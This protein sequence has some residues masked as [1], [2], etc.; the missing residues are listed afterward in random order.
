M[1]AAIAAG[2][3]RHTALLE[4]EKA[5]L[6][7]EATAK[8][9]A[10][11][12]D[13]LKADCAIAE[14]TLQ[15]MTAARQTAQDAPDRAQ[16]D[17]DAAKGYKADAERYA[18]ATAEK[19]DL[20]KKK[21]Q[22]TEAQARLGEVRAAAE[23]PVR[24]GPINLK[25]QEKRRLEETAALLDTVGCP[26]EYADS[27][28][29][30][31]EAVKARDTLPALEAEIAA[32]TLQ[33]AEAAERELAAI[34]EAEGALVAV[35]FDAA[36][37][38]TVLCTIENTKTAA[39]QYARL[40]ELKREVQ[41]AE[42]T[43]RG[44]DL[45]FHAA[46][47]QLASLRGKLATAQAAAAGYDPEALRDVR[48]ALLDGQRWLDMDKRLP[49]ARQ[50]RERA[51]ARLTEI[52]AEL[53]EVEQ[54]SRERQAEYERDSA[55]EDW[56][57][58]RY[59]LT[60]AE[61][62]VAGASETLRGLDQR[63]GSIDA[64]LSS[65]KDTRERA[66][67]LQEQAAQAA[68]Q[69]AIYEALKAAF[70]QDGIPHNIIR[71][72]IPVLEATATNIL[73]QMSGGRM[74]VE[75][76]TEKTLKSNTKKEVTTLDVIINDTTTGPLPYMSRSGGERVKAAL[77]VI[78]ALSEIKSSEAGVQLG[79][80]FIDEP[81]FLDADGVQA[82]CDALETI[83]SRYGDLKIMAITHDPAMKSRFPQ[84][85]GRGKDGGRLESNLC[86][87]SREFP[88]RFLPGNSQK[89]GANIGTT[90]KADGRLVS[91]LCIGPRQSSS[92]RTAGGMTAT[93][94]GSSCWSS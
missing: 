54:E 71:T 37:N 86:V 7:E 88:G 61:Q 77:S 84:S 2:V 1:E 58:L 36:R 92:W 89:G 62:A 3:Q 13:R 31:S 82:Y 51:A 67:A 79:F 34:K 19:T 78:L 26:A 18:A 5:L 75:F 90:E 22:F 72:I 28:R 93:L 49:A 29:F 30:L 47:S 81:P 10:E 45:R 69:A 60:Q 56:A 15:G 17:M 80:L 83:Q 85:V 53:A 27:C 46:E 52:A 35:G 16:R 41:R 43:L 12:V 32:L 39:E 57:S 4:K 6:A 38:M 74:S 59:A 9:K 40:P 8:A 11:E 65:G 64:A 42:D 87:T 70:S 68:T 20:D 25:A 63:I 24:K 48:A 23:A 73:G 33:S 91:P 66:K 44:A 21:Q 14:S 55:A 76:V 94:S 50:A